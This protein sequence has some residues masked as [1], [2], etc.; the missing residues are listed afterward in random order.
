MDV[1][2]EFFLLALQGDQIRFDGFSCFR[3]AHVKNLGRNP[4]AAFT[5]AAFKKLKEPKPKRP[6]VTVAAIEKLLL[7]AGR[8]FP[9]VTIHREKARPGVCW[10][11]KI[12]ELKGGT[13][14]L[15][16]I[17]PDAVW[18]YEPTWHKLNEITAVEF[19]GEYEKALS[20]V[21]GKPLSL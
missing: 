15:L 16:E 1:G 7:S 9:L 20:L 14:S 19:G 11:G 17:G 18:D 2:P 21:G 5:E 13:V 6:R 8:A 12:E 3:V 4:Y 10:I